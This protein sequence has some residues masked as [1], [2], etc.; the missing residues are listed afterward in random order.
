MIAEGQACPLCTQPL[1]RSTLGEFC[2]DESPLRITLS[3]MPALRCTA[4]HTYFAKRDFPMWLMRH[5]VDEDAAT[6]P[7]G[8]AKGMLFRKH[9][10]G[11]CG[12]ELA[13]RQERVHDFGFR[14]AH[15]GTEAF[16]VRL[17]MPVFRCAAC[18]KEQVRSAE[19]VKKLAPAALV[20]AFKAAGIKAPG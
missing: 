17:T 7:G 4:G 20:H 8:I 19:E 11:A 15:P 14:L 5:L 18:G 13:A 16:D 12:G 1:G 2:G 9:A 10:C 3:G 6:I